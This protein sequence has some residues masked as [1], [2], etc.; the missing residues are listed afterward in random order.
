MLVLRLES[1]A[2]TSPRWHR[3]RQSRSSTASQPPAWASSHGTTMGKPPRRDCRT[4]SSR[5]H[6]GDMRTADRHHHR[7]PHAGIGRAAQNMPALMISTA[8]PHAL[9]NQAE[10][11]GRH[12]AASAMAA[13][14]LTGET[15]I[16][17]PAQHRIR[18]RAAEQRAGHI[19]EQRQRREP[20]GARWSCR[21]PLADRW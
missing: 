5:A 8:A 1:A 7:A 21:V 16:A 19:G 11:Q 12:T 2:R 4:C 6:G 3:A 18:Q 9:T 15:L 20:A 13:H 17:G 14:A 10:D